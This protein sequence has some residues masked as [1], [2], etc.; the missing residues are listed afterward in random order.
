MNTSPSTDLYSVQSNLENNN[1][2]DSK[3]Y[4]ALKPDWSNYGEVQCNASMALGIGSGIDSN[5]KLLPIKQDTS[6]CKDGKVSFCLKS[7]FITDNNIILGNYILTLFVTI[8]GEP[9]DFSI[10]NEKSKNG[11]LQTVASI[12]ENTAL[13]IELDYINTIKGQNSISVYGVIYVPQIGNY[14]CLSD[15]D[16]FIASNNHLGKNAIYSVDNDITDIIKSSVLGKDDLEIN[17]IKNS[18]TGLVEQKY[19]QSCFQSPKCF[20]ISSRT[21]LNLTYINSYNGNLRNFS[22]FCIVFRNGEAIN[23]WNDSTTLLKIDISEKDISWKIP[24]KTNLPHNEYSYIAAVLFEQAD[25][26]DLSMPQIYM[27]RELFYITE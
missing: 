18:S 5:G 2:H 24:I 9:V 26:C 22:G 1:G 11:I 6:S 13:T 10:D 14:Y 3:K 27:Q 15:T 8:N 7:F 23:A 17:A 4:T 20:E 19:I 25:H 12:G 21:P 16:S